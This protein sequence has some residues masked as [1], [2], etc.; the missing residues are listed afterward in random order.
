MK[1]AQRQRHEAETL[2][3]AKGAPAAT[4]QAS[5][6]PKQCS[7]RWSVERRTPPGTGPF[8]PHRRRTGVGRD[9][10]YGD[11]LSDHAPGRK[12][13]GRHGEELTAKTMPADAATLDLSGLTGNA[14][15]TLAGYR[16]NGCLCHTI[17]LGFK[18]MKILAAIAELFAQID[19]GLAV[20]RRRVVVEAVGLTAPAGSAT[21]WANHGSS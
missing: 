8:Y 6:A 15:P 17:P 9:A 16:W 2:R 1:E 21:R 12:R 18:A 5:A 3:P 7:R 13:D 20:L 19:K 14:D 11:H 4:N 10:G